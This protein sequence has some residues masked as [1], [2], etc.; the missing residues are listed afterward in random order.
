[1]VYAYASAHQGNRVTAKTSRGRSQLPQR[2]LRPGE[3]GV[4][5]VRRPNPDGTTD[6]RFNSYDLPV[7]ERKYT[8]AK[9]GLI[10]DGTHAKMLFAQVKVVGGGFRSLVVV[11]M[12]VD[13]MH[14]FLE[15]C[16]DFLP[17]T[18]ELIAS[19]GLPVIP[20]LSLTE[21]PAQTVEMTA[22]VAAIARSEAETTLDFFHI[23]PASLHAVN[24]LNSDQLGIESVV[25]VNLPL[26]ALAPLLTELAKL[27]ESHPRRVIA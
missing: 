10:F 2:T 25:R 19:H 27:A 6:L 4:A 24:K 5:V 23:P 15:T 18:L 12:S 3:F 22:N 20:L 1:M 13:S 26:G 8:A 14:R 17:K 16:S 7:P 11:S 9:A 21:E